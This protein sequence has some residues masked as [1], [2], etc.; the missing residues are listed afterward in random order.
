[1]VRPPP[2]TLTVQQG[3]GCVRGGFSAQLLQ[4][5]TSNAAQKKSH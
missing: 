5:S 1:M 2:P 4:T 3:V